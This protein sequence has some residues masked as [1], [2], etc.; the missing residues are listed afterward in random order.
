MNIAENILK[1]SLQ[2]VYFL[3]GTALAGKTTM[4]ALLS[5]KHNL[6]PYYED[7]NGKSM[8]EFQS[9]CNEK[10][11]PQSNQHKHT[12]WEAHFGRTVEEFLAD[13]ARSENDNAYLQF[14]IIDLIKISQNNRVITDL[15]MPISLLP[16]IS[17][18]SRVACL[19]ASP[20]IVNC[21]NYGKRESH[22]SFLDCLLSLK[23]PEKKIA[24]QDE[25]FRIGVERM[26]EEVRKNNL[27][28]IVRTEESTIEDTLEKLEKHF[29]LEKAYV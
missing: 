16:E 11:Q 23:E 19:L 17:E 14:A 9:I 12:D 20:E 18:Y 27:F 6:I 25:V 4:T 24:V 10:Y 5:K 22:K 3:A 15:Y 28:N 26:F 21:E 2:N 1:H 7:W 13:E 29:Q 8:L